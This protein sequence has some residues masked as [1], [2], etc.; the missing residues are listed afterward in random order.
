[1]RYQIVSFTIIA[2]FI[3]LASGCSKNDNNSTPADSP[4]II[5]TTSPAPNTTYIN[6]SVLQIRGNVTDNNGLKTAK[7]EIKNNANSSILYQQNQ[8]TGNVTYFDLNW[9]WTLTGITTLVNATVRITIT[10]R[11]NN[12][13]TKDIPVVLID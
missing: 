8:S 9:D 4:A 6:G 1:M 2:A 12:Q 7:V 13:V 10:D 5:T 11:Y 3:S